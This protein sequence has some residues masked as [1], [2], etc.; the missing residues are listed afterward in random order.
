MYDVILHEFDSEPT[1]LAWFE[2]LEEAINK[3]IKNRM[4]LIADVEYEIYVEKN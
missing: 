2:T 4:N 3:Y 1:R